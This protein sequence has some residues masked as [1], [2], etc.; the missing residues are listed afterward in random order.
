MINVIVCGGVGSV[1]EDQ[2]RGFRRRIK[3]LCPP[4][5]RGEPGAGWPLSWAVMEVGL[6]RVA[7]GL[8]RQDAGNQRTC[9]GKRTESSVAQ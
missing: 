6:D 3:H 2:K 8:E 7:S 9:L 4:Q 1:R 5:G